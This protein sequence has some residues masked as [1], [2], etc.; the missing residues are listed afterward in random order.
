MRKT[1]SKEVKSAVRNYLLEVAE[2]EELES[3]NDLKE[4][5]VSE[6]G[7]RIS[8]IGE[9]NACMDW[10]RGLGINVDFCYSDIVTL[11]AEWLDDTEEHQEKMIDKNGDDLYWLLLAREIVASK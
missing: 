3:I 11:L 4:K 1:N 5:F 6:Y 2:V 10:L 8:K 7:W 9:L